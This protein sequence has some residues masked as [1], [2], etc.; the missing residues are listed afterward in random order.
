[1]SQRPPRECHLSPEILV[2]SYRHGVVQL[3]PAGCIHES[4]NTACNKTFFLASLPWPSHP[5]LQNPRSN[6]PSSDPSIPSSIKRPNPSG[7]ALLVSRLPYTR[8][9]IFGLNCSSPTKTS[10]TT[11]QHIYSDIRHP[12]QSNIRQLCP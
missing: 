2:P 4:T 11:H 6:G 9:H 12:N 8:I 3:D 10:L 7:S 5:L 1:M